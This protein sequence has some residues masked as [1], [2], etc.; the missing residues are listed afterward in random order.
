MP[1]TTGAYAVLY[2]NEDPH[3]VLNRLMTREKKGELEIE[4]SWI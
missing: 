4:E 3:L 2:E 1:V